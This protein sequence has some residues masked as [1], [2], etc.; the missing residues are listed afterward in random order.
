MTGT[1]ILE[2]VFRRFHSVQGHFPGAVIHGNDRGLRAAA[3][4]VAA[5]IEHASAASVAADGDENRCVQRRD[6]VIFKI[7]SGKRFAGIKTDDGITLIGGAENAPVCAGVAP[8]ADRSRTRNGSSLVACAD[9]LAVGANSSGTGAET[10]HTKVDLRGTELNALDT[11]VEIGIVH[12]FT[13]VGNVSAA[14]VTDDRVNR[15]IDGYAF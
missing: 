9:G 14:A 15:A 8:G 3:I 7:R 11:G 2:P 10:F 13:V 6:L 4:H 5:H 12:V 1:K